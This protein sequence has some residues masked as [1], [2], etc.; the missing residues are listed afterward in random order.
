MRGE[1]SPLNS[2]E[3]FAASQ[4]AASVMTLF[5]AS[6]DSP[7]HIPAFTTGVSV[8]TI[9]DS[10]VGISVA[11]PSS[12]VSVST[13]R[14]AGHV[15][16]NFPAMPSHHQPLVTMAEMTFVAPLAQFHLSVTSSA[17]SWR[18]FLKCV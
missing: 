15:P 2:S 7:S 18:R 10:S 8:V 9:H 17:I 14:N 16:P 13:P 6:N 12:C 1:T 5:V 11:V 4:C 3:T